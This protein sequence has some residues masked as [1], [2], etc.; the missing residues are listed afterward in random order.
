MSAAGDATPASVRTLARTASRS[1]SAQTGRYVVTFRC[2]RE[3]RRAKSMKAS[4]GTGQEADEVAAGDDSDELSAVDDGDVGDVAVVHLR[5][6]AVERVVGLGHVIVGDHDVGDG[7]P[8]GLLQLV[9][10]PVQRRRQ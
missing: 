8:G 4:A 5:R 1:I 9:L 6:H 10:E 2:V 3:L 7:G